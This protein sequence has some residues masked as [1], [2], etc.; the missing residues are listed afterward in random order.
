MTHQYDSSRIG[1]GGKQGGCVIDVTTLTDGERN[2]QRGDC[3]LLDCPSP[4]AGCREPVSKVRGA[5]VAMWVQLC[6][7]DATPAG[8]P[9]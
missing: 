7:V 5:A 6:A 8:S 4:T 1:V 2:F 9:A 3:G